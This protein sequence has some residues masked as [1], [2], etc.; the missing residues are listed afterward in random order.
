MALSLRRANAVKEY[1][2][3]RGI[4]AYKMETKGFGQTKPV[5]SNDTD[6]GRASNRRVE[7]HPK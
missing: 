4:S 3:N 1:L 5:A 6:S 7:I 2:V